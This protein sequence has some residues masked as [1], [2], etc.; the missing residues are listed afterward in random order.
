MP[1]SVMPT[2]TEARIGAIKANST[3]ALPERRRSAASTVPRPKIVMARLFDE[4]GRA[5]ADCGDAFSGTMNLEIGVALEGDLV[6]D[7]LQAAGAG[8]R[9]AGEVND[10]LRQVDRPDDVLRRAAAEVVRAALRGVAV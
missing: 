5:T 4:L 8:L 1:R 10:L 6:G 2:S 9:P 7:D 3:A